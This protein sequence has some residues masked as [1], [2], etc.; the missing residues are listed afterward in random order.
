MSSDELVVEVRLY[1]GV[2][3]K[4]PREEIYVINGSNFDETVFYNFILFFT[5]Y[6]NY[7]LICHL[8]YNNIINNIQKLIKDILSIYTKVRAIESSEKSWIGQA[9]VARRDQFGDFHLG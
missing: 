6:N 2:E 1:D 3:A 5:S 9:V 8:Y 4:L 7:F